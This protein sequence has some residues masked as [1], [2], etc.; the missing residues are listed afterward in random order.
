VGQPQAGQGQC[1]RQLMEQ[2]Q[3]PA[4]QESVAGRQPAGQQVVCRQQQQL[5]QDA[6]LV[7]RCSVTSSFAGT[8]ESAGPAAVAVTAYAE[9]AWVVSM[10]LGLLGNCLPDWGAVVMMQ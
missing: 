2:Q 6:G 4:Q 1:R 5:L 10:V 7:G 8:G 3:Q 9:G